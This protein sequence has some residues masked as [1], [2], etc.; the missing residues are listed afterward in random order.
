MTNFYRKNNNIAFSVSEALYYSIS[1]T[2][3]KFIHIAD[4]VKE[5]SEHGI[6]YYKENPRDIRTLDL[7]VD[8]Q[9]NNK[10]TYTEDSLTKVTKVTS[11]YNSVDSFVTITS[12]SENVKGNYF[13]NI[14]ISN[15]ISNKNIYVGFVSDISNKYRLSDFTYR[16]EY[17]PWAD[18]YLYSYN[19]QK[20]LSPRPDTN[21]ININIY[22]DKFT[23]Q[24]VCT[25]KPTVKSIHFSDTF[26]RKSNLKDGWHEHTNEID[27]TIYYSNPVLKKISPT[28]PLAVN[29]ISVHIKF[30]TTVSDDVSISSNSNYDISHLHR[31]SSGNRDVSAEDSWSCNLIPVD[32]VNRNDVSFCIDTYTDV[33]NNMS[34]DSTTVYCDIHTSEDSTFGDI[35][36]LT[37]KYNPLLLDYPKTYTGGAYKTAN[38]YTNDLYNPLK[39]T[40][41][42]YRNSEFVD[43]SIQFNQSSSLFSL[44]EFILEDLDLD[45]RVKSSLIE[46]SPITTFSISEY[47]E[48]QDG[49]LI[50]ITKMPH[51]CNHMIPIHIYSENGSYP[52]LY[53]SSGTIINAIRNVLYAKPVNNNTFVLYDISSDY[54][55]GLDISS[56][57]ESDNSYYFIKI[58]GSLESKGYNSRYNNNYQYPSV[59]TFWRK[60]NDQ[61]MRSRPSDNIVLTGLGYNYSTGL[62]YDDFD[63]DDYLID[64]K[65]I[66]RISSENISRTRDYLDISDISINN[67]TWSFKIRS[68]EKKYPLLTHIKDISHTGERIHLKLN[69]YKDIYG[70]YGNKFQRDIII[71][72]PPLLVYHSKINIRDLLQRDGSATLKLKFNKPINKHDICIVPHENVHILGWRAHTTAEYKEHKYS[73]S[74]S[75]F[76]GYTPL[77]TQPDDYMVQNGTSLRESPVNLA[78]VDYVN[79]YW[80]YTTDE[81][82][83]VDVCDISWDKSQQECDIVLATVS[84]VFQLL[85]D[86]STTMHSKGKD[87]TYES[88]ISRAYFSDVYY[89]HRISYGYHDTTELKY[90]LERDLSHTPLVKIKEMKDCFDISGDYRY[91]ESP[92]GNSIVSY[93]PD[94]NMSA[95]AGASNPQEEIECVIQSYT[96]TVTDNNT[97]DIYYGDTLILDIWTSC[98]I[99]PRILYLDVSGF[100]ATEEPLSQA[101][102]SSISRVSYEMLDG[103]MMH[104]RIKYVTQSLYIQ[105]EEEYNSVSDTS[106]DVSIHIS[107]TSV[108]EYQYNKTISLKIKCGKDLSIE[109]FTFDE[110]YKVSLQFDNSVPYFDYKEHI[111]KY[112]DYGEL[113]MNTDDGGALWEGYFKAYHDISHKLSLAINPEFYLMRISNGVSSTSYQTINTKLVYPASNNENNIFI[114]RFQIDS[115]HE[116]DLNGNFVIKRDEIVYVNIE[117][118][119]SLNNDIISDSSSKISLSLLGMNDIMIFPDDNSYSNYRLDTSVTKYDISFRIKNDIILD[120]SLILDI[121]IPRV[122]QD[123]LN[124]KLNVLKIYTYDSDNISYTRMVHLHKSIQLN[125]DTTFDGILGPEL[126]LYN[127]NIYTF[128]LLNQGDR[129][130][131]YYKFILTDSLSPDGEPWITDKNITPDISTYQE[132]YDRYISGGGSHTGDISFNLHIRPDIGIVPNTNFYFDDI[133]KPYRGSYIAIQHVT[134]LE[135]DISNSA[136]EDKVCTFTASDNIIKLFT[137]H[138]NNEIVHYIFYSKNNDNNLYV[139]ICGTPTDISFNN[140]DDS[141]ITYSSDK[142]YIFNSTSLLVL[143]TDLSIIRDEEWCV[144][145]LDLHASLNSISNDISYL[146]WWKNNDR[147]ISVSEYTDSSGTLHDVSSIQHIHIPNLHIFVRQVDKVNNSPLLQLVGYDIL[148]RSQSAKCVNVLNLLQFIYYWNIPLHHYYYYNDNISNKISNYISE[149]IIDDIKNNGVV[150]NINKYIISMCWDADV[151]T[152][153]TAYSRRPL[154]NTKWLHPEPDKQY[155]IDY[156]DIVDKSHIYRY[157]SDVSIYDVSYKTISGG[158]FNN[159]NL[160]IN[161]RINVKGRGLDS[162]W[163]D[164]IL[165]RDKATVIERNNLIYILHSGTALSISETSLNNSATPH[166]ERIIRN[167]A[168]E[169]NNFS[170]LDS[171]SEYSSHLYYVPDIVNIKLVVEANDTSNISIRHTDDL[172][173]NERIQYLWQNKGNHRLTITDISDIFYDKLTTIPEYIKDNKILFTFSNVSVKEIKELGIVYKIGDISNHSVEVKTISPT[174]TVYTVS[175]SRW[176]VSTDLSWSTFTVSDSTTRYYK[177]YRNYSISE[178]HCVQDAS[179]LKNINELE[180]GKLYIMNTTILPTYQLDGTVGYDAPFLITG[181][182]DPDQTFKYRHDTGSRP[183][184][185]NIPTPI[186]RA[187]TIISDKLEL[188]DSNT[189]DRCYVFLAYDMWSGSGDIS[190]NLFSEPNLQSKLDLNSSNTDEYTIVDIL[191]YNISINTYKNNHDVSN[192]NVIQ[193]AWIY[194]VSENILNI[195]GSNLVYENDNTWSR[196]YDYNKEYK[197]LDIS[198]KTILY[199]SSENKDENRSSRYDSSG[200]PYSNKTD[201]STYKILTV[202]YN[203]ILTNHDSSIHIYDFDKNKWDTLSSHF[204]IIKKDSSNKPIEPS[205]NKMLHI[206]TIDKSDPIDISTGPLFKLDTTFVVEVIDGLLYALSSNMP[207]M[208]YQ[209]VDNVWRFDRNYRIQGNDIS[210]NIIPTTLF[211]TRAKSSCVLNG[212]I[213][214]CTSTAIYKHTPPPKNYQKNRNNRNN[215]S[216]TIQVQY[217]N[218]TLLV[219]DGDTTHEP[220]GINIKDDHLYP[221]ILSYY[222]DTKMH[223]DFTPT[224]MRPLLERAEQITITDKSDIII[225]SPSPLYQDKD[226]SNVTFYIPFQLDS[227]DIS[228]NLSYD[229]SYFERFGSSITISDS[230]ILVTSSNNYHNSNINLHGNLPV[231]LN[232]LGSKQNKVIDYKH[233]L[234]DDMHIYSNRMSSTT[235]SGIIDLREL[236]MLKNDA[237]TIKVGNNITEVYLNEKYKLI[238]DYPYTDISDIS[239]YDS[240]YILTK[241]NN[242]VLKIEYVGNLLPDIIFTPRTTEITYNDIPSNDIIKKSILENMGRLAY[243]EEPHSKYQVNDYFVTINGSLSI[244]DASEIYHIWQYTENRTVNVYG[245]PLIDTISD[246]TDNIKKYLEDISIRKDTGYSIEYVN[247]DIKDQ[248][249][250]IYNN[251][252]ISTVI[253]IFEETVINDTIYQPDVHIG[254]NSHE[255]LD[256]SGDRSI[257]I[258]ENSDAPLLF[259]ISGYEKQ[260]FTNIQN[261]Y[262]PFTANNSGTGTEDISFDEYTDGDISHTFANIINTSSEINIKPRFFSDISIICKLGSVNNKVTWKYNTLDTSSVIPREVNDCSD[263]IKA[264]LKVFGRYDT[265][266]V[267]KLVQTLVDTQ[268]K[269]AEKLD[270]SSLLTKYTSPPNVESLVQ[271]NGNNK[272]GAYVKNQLSIRKKLI[273]LIRLYDSTVDASTPYWYSHS[274]TKQIDI[275]TSRPSVPLDVVET[276]Y[277]IKLLTTLMCIQANTVKPLEGVDSFIPSPSSPRQL[278]LNELENLPP[279]N[280]KIVGYDHNN[281]A[282][283]DIYKT[284]TNTLIRQDIDN[285]GKIKGNTVTGVQRYRKN[286]I[287]NF[288]KERFKNINFTVSDIDYDDDSFTLKSIGEGYTVDLGDQKAATNTEVNKSKSFVRDLFPES[289]ILDISKSEVADSIFAKLIVD[290]SSFPHISD[291]SVGTLITDIGFHQNILDISD[292][293]KKV[294]TYTISDTPISNKLLRMLQFA[295]HRLYKTPLD[296]Y[297]NDMKSTDDDISTQLYI[298]ISGNSKLIEYFNQIPK[299]EIHRK[300]ISG[301]VSIVPHTKEIVSSGDSTSQQGPFLSYY[302]KDISMADM[303]IKGDSVYNKIDGISMIEGNRDISTIGEFVYRNRNDKSMS[304]LNIKENANRIKPY[305]IAELLEVYNIYIDASSHPD[306]YYNETHFDGK[307]LSE[308]LQLLRN[309]LELELKYRYVSDDYLE[310]KSLQGLRQ[311]YKDKIN[312]EDEKWL[313]SATGESIKKEPPDGDP[314]IYT[315]NGGLLTDFGGYWDNIAW[316]NT[317]SLQFDTS[318]SPRTDLSKNEYKQAISNILDISVNSITVIDVSS[319]EYTHRTFIESKVSDIDKIKFDMDMFN[320]TIKFRYNEL[321]GTGTNDIS[322]LTYT[323]NKL[324]EVINN[325]ITRVNAFTMINPVDKKINSATGVVHIQL[326]LDSPYTD[327]SIS[328]WKKDIS[329]ILDVSTFDPLTVVRVNTDLDYRYKLWDIYLNPNENTEYSNNKITLGDNFKTND[330]SIVELNYEIDTAKPEIDSKNRYTNIVE[331]IFNEKLDSTKIP[332]VMA[333]GLMGTQFKNEKTLLLITENENV[334]KFTV[335]EYYDQMG[336]MGD[337]STFHI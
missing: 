306:K 33:C 312:D 336:N 275:H 264:E 10:Q 42:D 183:L 197:Y 272:W 48:E 301:D 15:D 24:D 92:S 123:Q 318:M 159:K 97:I 285:E 27:G 328:E 137:L 170:R 124:G 35:S 294:T 109:N 295:S 252:D 126:Q 180:Q 173:C 55:K 226:N 120:A 184:W 258:H 164:S 189:M 181:M 311:S 304:P 11:P 99:P 84:E 257:T 64:N 82:S 247:D 225:P 163:D 177:E 19:T 96:H 202:D 58:E 290:T 63:Y 219:K 317:K 144:E 254:N 337:A 259:D 135:P 111:Y 329:Y 4:T 127:N 100:V 313:E 249:E 117:L 28:K 36:T 140:K 307:T 90:M 81:Y 234:I 162:N 176:D 273:D 94:Y 288:K 165:D 88:M 57:S 69:R 114:K 333:T 224:I 83:L 138:V 134:K 142:F 45:A 206:D 330:D 227:I 95:A 166:R 321:V 271:R 34:G 115:D 210:T 335:S 118:Y 152:T 108:E 182:F 263:L 154:Y 133:S 30:A 139:D 280:N 86:V 65:P 116:R 46:Y 85:E 191:T 230:S 89:E 269:F 326:M 213:Y 32:N 41:S 244:E 161:T 261:R 243:Y 179:T 132:Y 208:L 286:D 308:L 174:P 146:S 268:H 157:T 199:S 214:Y 323:H 187:V 216:T 245:K 188:N 262:E 212:V 29:D 104:W 320:N 250:K 20:I 235:D 125:V 205:G 171:I 299:R 319:D 287:I 121:S 40:I 54:S 221:V 52:E 241:N 322:S 251:R 198:D 281:S 278:K 267:D 80:Q 107:M 193:G 218:N 185:L 228:I 37:I 13:Y 113:T 279:A 266:N 260:I 106:Q 316:N 145:I 7:N 325:D 190:F 256:I 9:Y 26:L 172:S 238:L 302:H 43:I 50:W 255:I 67:H 143:N 17:S 186:F 277:L 77:T 201:I 62:D 217:A 78:I 291:I 233:S 222:K 51:H 303:T 122:Q 232:I 192:N 60:H 44:N 102:S 239:S 59:I 141:L 14:D 72:P 136:S 70:N 68:N 130:W 156:G 334:V 237:S 119:Q 300:L 3:A 167:Q 305:I 66:E 331:I 128:N 98:R 231:K 310:G 270:V 53:T 149:E 160:D 101:Y 284:F 21:I 211:E 155:I 283:I 253:N 103:T 236:S 289:R 93:I 150:N 314:A 265:V 87:V 292:T 296:K 73:F 248:F 76:A 204:E 5:L 129:L 71:E 110:D 215:P 315:E 75:V 297:I 56:A 168:I 195:G 246:T 112:K 25:I 169:Y 18:S 8:N 61:W 39:G 147:I 276:S 148:D 200:F 332:E 131:E 2:D 209:L 23:F 153:N 178:S 175:K 38:T 12:V 74:H 293:L 49:N 327:Y 229:I 22:H 324:P 223:I 151:L 105:T 282:S 207:P 220:I 196:E 31:T 194:D 158:D 242:S 91:K 298:D 274:Q 16:D 240:K 47:K 203:L 309:K 79:T 6:A 1:D